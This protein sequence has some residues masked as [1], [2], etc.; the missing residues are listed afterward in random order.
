[1]GGAIDYVKELEQLHQ[2]LQ[3]QKRTKKSAGTPPLFQPRPPPPQPLLGFW[4]HRHQQLHNAETG[5]PNM[6]TR[7]K[8]DGRYQYLEEL[9]QGYNQ[10]YFCR[11]KIQPIV[12][13]PGLYLA[14][15]FQIFHATEKRPINV[16]IGESLFCFI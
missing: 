4:L 14:R 1:M 6:E 2:S 13:D 7:S 3:A 12:V 5:S 16:K 9:Q 10:W 15:R 11:K 8:N